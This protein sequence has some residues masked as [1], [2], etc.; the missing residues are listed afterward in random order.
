MGTSY[1]AIIKLRKR[2]WLVQITNQTTALLEPTSPLLQDLRLYFITSLSFSLA[3]DS[4]LAFPVFQDLD[5]QKS[6]GWSF[7]DAPSWVA[8][9]L[10]VVVGYG[11]L[12]EYRGRVPSQHVTWG[13]GITVTYSW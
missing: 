10:M 7:A 1:G 6:P 2:L 9:A 3:W 4:L 12:K 13:P 11:V 8:C 5:T